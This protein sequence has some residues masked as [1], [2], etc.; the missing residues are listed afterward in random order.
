MKKLFS[1]IM[2]LGLL[3][4]GNAYAE[5]NWQKRN[6]CEKSEYK[7]LC[8]IIL[9]KKLVGV[10][11]IANFKFEKGKIIALI[12]VKK[13]ENMSLLQDPD[14]SYVAK[15]TGE[16]LVY[17]NADGI[18][19]T[20]FAPSSPMENLICDNSNKCINANSIRS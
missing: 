9:D 11:T 10:N 14:P 19:I 15:Y 17:K 18:F 13:R 6:L 16:Y 3:L 20:E 5:I 1:L 8:S 4:S 7:D 12:I 2:V